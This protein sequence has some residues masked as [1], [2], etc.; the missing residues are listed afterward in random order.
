M[1]YFDAAVLG[2]VQGLTEFLPVSSSGHLVLAEALLHVKKPGVTLEV[3]VHLGTLVAVIIYFWKQLWRLMKALFKRTMARERAL[4]LYLIVGTIPA[5]LAGILL[6]DFFEKTFSNPVETSIEL[7]I[8]GL[9]LLV[10]RFFRAGTG[11]VALPSAVVMGIGQ[12]IS[13]LPGISRSGTTIVSGMLMKVEPALAAEFS[14][15]LSIPA[16]G[17]AILLELNDLFEMEGQVAGQYLFAA[18]LSFIFG[19]ISVYWVLRS[20]KRGKFEYFAY[21]CFAAGLL[22]LYLFL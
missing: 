22:G 21:Y 4:I 11:L 18:L 3:M 6:K 2:I 16:I 9:I 17:G 13:I 10:P 1:T 12:A 15:L 19:L 8:T 5:G 20:V 7:I 14:F